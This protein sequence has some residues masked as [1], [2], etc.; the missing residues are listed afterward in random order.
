MLNETC[1]NTI[2]ESKDLDECVDAFYEHVGNITNEC[3]PLTK[4]TKKIKDRPP[5]MTKAARKSI[6]RKKCA[7]N[8]YQ[9]SPNHQKYMQYVKQRNA[10]SKKLRGA[11]KQFEKNLAKQC[12][13]YPKRLFKYANFKNKTKKNVIRLRNGNGD[14]QTDDTENAELLNQFFQSVFTYED[15]APELILNQSSNI[16]WGDNNTNE[17]F[18]YTGK[19]PQHLLTELRITDDMIREQLKDIDPFK[20]NTKDCIHPKL[21]KEAGESMIKPLNIIFNKSLV[22]GTVPKRWKYATVTALHKGED[23]H[24]CKN[25]RPVSITSVICR[26]MERILKKHIIRHLED[27]SILTDEQHGF[28]SK[29]SCLSNLLLAMEELTS[30]YD[31]GLPVDEIFLDLQKAFDKVP[32][33][34]LLYKLKKIGIESD[35]LS[36]IESFLSE[37]YQRVS[38]K[39]SYSK[40]SKVRS[41]V[42][43]GSVLGPILFIIYINDLPGT[44]KASC[45]IFA[46]D[47]KLIKKIANLKDAH[48]LQEDLNTLCE[49]AN[50][51]KLNFNATKCHILHIGKRNPIYSYTINGNEL[52]HVKTE[53]D[54][55]III[56]E[57]LKANENITHHVKKA[58]KMLGLIKR[59]FTFLDKDS[60]LMLYKTYIRPHLEYCQQACYPYLR[61]DIDILEKV[62]KRATKLVRSIHDLPYE[63]R[64]RELKLYSL[65]DRR[66]R[67]DLIVVHQIINGKMD[68][69]MRKLFV[70]AEERH[71][72]GHQYKLKLPKICH[73]EIRRNSFSHRI[74][75]PW[76]NLS[77]QIVNS[78]TTDEFKRKYDKHVLYG[79]KG[80]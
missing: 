30:I 42:P 7:W 19:V 27:N 44:V 15:D 80:L 41:G 59:T 3:V 2:F 11:K 8:R 48:H 60:F 13:K 25:Y 78:K 10:T 24:D 32:H 58:N 53:K 74:V 5:W 57:D 50:T 38:I 72:R 20:S 26:M 67:G 79:S 1:W 33:Q 45:S 4:V 28:V 31:E 34:R 61:K 54:L 14:I 51:W 12:K 23:R 63:D 36:W 71:S 29:R 62:Q 69:D 64:L 66:I 6:R 65:E 40:W 37:R 68:I 73:T 55:G 49:W 52:E 56:S 46:D 21:I 17:P 22:L 39:Q 9:T 18:D 75:L 43:Q 16:L 47:T 77:P 76:N 70:F 35:M